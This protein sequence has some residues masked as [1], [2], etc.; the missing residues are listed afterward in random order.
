MVH[1]QGDRAVARTQPQPNDGIRFSWHSR[2]ADFDR[3]AWD[4][5]ALPLDTPLLEY[6]WLNLMETSGSI[7]PPNGWG[8]CHLGVWQGDRLIGAA[9]LYLKSHS[10]GEFVFDHAWADLAG[11]LGIDYYPK[12][13]GMSPVTPVVGYRFLL[14]PMID[15]QRLTAAM[16]TGIEAFCRRQNLSGFSFLFADDKWSPAL[17]TYGMQP[18]RHQR[19]V[20]QN[21][22][23]KT[24]ADYLRRFKTNQR[25]NI[26]RERQLVE[27]QGVKVGVYAGADIPP[28]WADLMYRFYEA[29]NAKFGPWGCKYLTRHFFSGLF[30]R[31]HHR[32]I[33]IAAH[34]ADDPDLPVAMS[35][36]LTKG[37]WLYGRYWGCR[38]ETKALHFELCYYKPIEWCIA[39]GI[40]YFDPGAGSA[41]KV[42]RGFQSLANTS[43]H[44]FCDARL[45]R[46]MADHID[47][48]NQAE[49]AHIDE[50]NR[51]LPFANHTAAN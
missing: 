20:W 13:V 3:D 43:W 39:H 35:L 17:Q 12:L 10:A 5:L 51:H 30:R 49:Q 24:F 18:W 38:R 15:A 48:I 37:D 27:Q 23:F 6:E 4:A 25:R 19:F 34:A 8:P 31:H 26:K 21:E 16:L 41:H 46:I 11:R 50:L 40:H 22:N 1:Q 36:F 44:R 32:M 29:T 45:E 7:A 9:P 28:S 47:E 14:D 2:L 33:I 42:R